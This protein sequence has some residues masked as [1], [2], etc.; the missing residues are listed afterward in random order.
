MAELVAGRQGPPRRCLGGDRRGARAR[1]RD[2]PDHRAAERVV[3]VDP[4]PRGR[5]G[6]DR[7]PARHR[8]G[9]VLAARPRLP[10]RRAGRAA[11]SPTA[12]SRGGRWRASPATTAPP[13]RR[14]STRSPPWRRR[15]ACCPA[16]SRWRGCSSRATDVVP[17]PGTKRVAYLEQ[18][19]GALDV[20][21]T[22]DELARL[23]ALADQVA[24]RP[25]K[26]QV[27]AERHASRERRLGPLVDLAPPRVD[28]GQHGHDEVRRAADQ[29]GH[30]EADPADQEAADQAAQRHQREAARRRQRADPAHQVLGHPLVDHRA[31][32][33][34][35]EARRR[36]RPP[37]RSRGCSR[38]G[39]PGP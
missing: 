13:T 35:E 22:D 32:D 31:Q 34:V 27:T 9:A 15:T 21:L 6:A 29:H 3:A 25:L 8:P 28:R 4:R 12:T 16:R 19:V 38:A 33:R 18:N 26:P 37:R 17:I 2:A 39:C 1:A 11:R 5:R 24:G 36:S 14:S 20:T 23:D 10:H 7:A 30:A